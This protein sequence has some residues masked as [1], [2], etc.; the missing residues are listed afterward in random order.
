MALSNYIAQTLICTLLIALT[1]SPWHTRST[2]W[3]AIVVIWMTQLY[4]SSFWLRRHRF[5]PLEWL[6]RS[7]TYRRVEA[8]RRLS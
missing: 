1:P 7:A 4:G 3:V 8:L 6:W 2:L 5:G